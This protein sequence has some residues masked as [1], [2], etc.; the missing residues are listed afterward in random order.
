MVANCPLA[1]GDAYHAGHASLGLATS[2][3][4][5][6]CGALSRSRP[7]SR[8]RATR[9]PTARLRDVG[10]RPLSPQRRPHRGHRGHPRRG[11]RTPRRLGIVRQVW[12]WR[13]GG[14]C[15][16]AWPVVAAYPQ[17]PA[18]H[19]SASPARSS[20]A[21]R[22]STA[23]AWPRNWDPPI[24]ASEAEFRAVGAAPPP[25]G[26]A[27]ERPPARAR[28]SARRRATGCGR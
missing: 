15:A 25:P 10:A 18:P 16:A 8:R 28:S 13:G 5:A 2:P 19:A 11:R 23:P 9:P 21:P 26:T 3:A 14:C 4:S 12:T 7:A 27:A 24:A 17:R 6:S 1:R 22:R 20:R